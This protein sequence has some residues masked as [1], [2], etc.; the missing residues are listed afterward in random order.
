MKLQNSQS[1]WNEIWNQ[2]T[3][4]ERTRLHKS[5]VFIHTVYSVWWSVPHL[6][7]RERE[8]ADKMLKQWDMGENV[9]W[10]LQMAQI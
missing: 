9:L 6:G 8:A 1:S 2:E 3:D 5:I 4:Y 7:I 10:L